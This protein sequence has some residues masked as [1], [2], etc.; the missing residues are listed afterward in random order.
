MKIVMRVLYGEFFFSLRFILWWF[1]GVMVSRFSL[2]DTGELVDS[3]GMFSL[4]DCF[5]EEDLVLVEELVEFLN[6]QD[7]LLRE[8]VLKYGACVGELNAL[9]SKI[10]L[11]LGDE[12]KDCELL[13]SVDEDDVYL[14]GRLVELH[15]LM[16]ILL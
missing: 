12:I 11:V 16:R 4:S 1:L 15:N 6:K 2:S 9:K 7:V 13:A 5:V 10:S 3:T 14:Q 8:S